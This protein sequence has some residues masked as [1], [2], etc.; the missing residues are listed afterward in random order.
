VKCIK[1]AGEAKARARISR[2]EESPSKISKMSS[3]GIFS[4]LED[5]ILKLR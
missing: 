5:S 4:S 2:G 1:V 3:A